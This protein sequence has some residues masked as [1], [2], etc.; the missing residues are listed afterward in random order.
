MQRITRDKLTVVF[1]RH[2]PPVVDMLEIGEVDIDEAG[3]VAF[4]AP[5]V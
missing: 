1:D 2:I 5:H 4:P 3:K